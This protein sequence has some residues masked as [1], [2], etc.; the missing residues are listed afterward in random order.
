MEGGLTYKEPL[1]QAVPEIQTYWSMFKEKNHQN[2]YVKTQIKKE[3]LVV[4]K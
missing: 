3:K 2:S 4:P 1:E